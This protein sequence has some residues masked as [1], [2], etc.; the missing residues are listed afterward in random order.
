[1]SCERCSSDNGDDA[2]YCAS[3]GFT[4][5]S[6]PPSIEIDAKINVDPP[7]VGEQ[8]QPFDSGYVDRTVSVGGD[9]ASSTVPAPPPP[10]PPPPQPQPPQDPGSGS[11]NR[12]TWLAMAGALFAVFTLVVGGVWLSTRNNSD[13]QQEDVSPSG[14]NRDEPTDESASE[15]PRATDRDDDPLVLAT[16]LPETGNLSFFEPPTVAGAQL[17]VADINGSGGVLGADVELVL[18]DSGD[19]VQVASASVAR[20]LGEGADVFIGA[21][22]STVSLEVIDEVIASE[23]MMI[24]PANSSTVFTTYNDQGRYFRTSSHDAIQAQALANLIGGDLREGIVVGSAD[25]AVGDGVALIVRTDEYAVNLALLLRAALEAE[26]VDV[27]LDA[28]YDTNQTD[29][30]SI[31]NQVAAS[32]PAAIVILGLTETASILGELIDV[33][34]GPSQ[35]RIYGSDGNIGQG[36]ADSFGDP[37]V[38][39]G[40][41]G[42]APLFDASSDP[43]FVDRLVTVDPSLTFYDYAAETY[44]AVVIAALSAI[45]AGSS[46]ATSMAAEVN[47]VTR[48]G[49]RCESFVSCATLVQGG[50]DVDY[51]GVSGALEFT[52]SGEPSVASVIVYEF[53]STGTLTVDGSI[54]AGTPP[55]GPT[56]TT[57]TMPEPTT[58][59]SAENT[60]TTTPTATVPTASA[61]PPTIATTEAPPDPSSVSDLALGDAAIASLDEG[62]H[63]G[64]QWTLSVDAL[65]V[66]VES[67]CGG[68]SLVNRSRTAIAGEGM[69][70]WVIDFTLTNEGRSSFARGGAPSLRLTAQTLEGSDAETSNECIPVF[71]FGLPDTSTVERMIFNVPVGTTGLQ[72][73][74]NTGV[75]NGWNGRTATWT[76]PRP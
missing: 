65:N 51:D 26:G 68:S 10:Q 50:V 20:L 70:L 48:G 74:W 11:Q 19:N 30:A 13:T 57:T 49:E 38:L 12:T 37:S 42:T 63:Q 17:A 40:I 55:E 16:L 47:D 1:M 4:L 62:E 54:L 14:N 61:P 33:E 9:A 35:R 32:D 66:A 52:D 3:C 23:S 45:A 8:A 60:A 73:R 71:S 31:A 46:D 72:F 58:T 34:Y 41:R 53:D 43:D 64:D 27:V 2:V 7:R 76:L 6:V 67:E 36:L 39:A 56:T 22:S 75:I 21:V 44:D 59:A 28:N 18:G 69:E 15:Q 29:F 5:R 25:D 24:S